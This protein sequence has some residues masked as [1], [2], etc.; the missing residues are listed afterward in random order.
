MYT[1]RTS[2]GLSDEKR[3]K[4]DHPA[5]IEKWAQRRN[6]GQQEQAQVIEVINWYHYDYAP[7]V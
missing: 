2:V 7:L 3:L 4:L 6:N 5:E 1:V